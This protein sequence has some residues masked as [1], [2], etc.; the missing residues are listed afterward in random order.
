MSTPERIQFLSAI[1][2]TSRE[3]ARL[4]AFYRDVLGL[5]LVEERH[6]TVPQHWGCEL[7]DVHFAIHPRDGAP[8]PG[9]IRLAFWVFDLKT[10]A[11]DLERRGVRLRY[12]IRR[13]GPTSLI[14][15]I[16]D[17]DGNEIELTQMGEDWLRHLAEHRRQ[18]ADVLV[19]VSR[20]S[21]QGGS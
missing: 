19:R 18:G 10:F 12:P 2:L 6:G 15:A 4:T 7:G 11:E 3:P 16:V 5:P 20:P 8:P 17:P 13:L 9:P 14:T 21:D 1:L